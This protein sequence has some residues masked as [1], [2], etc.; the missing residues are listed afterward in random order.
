[1]AAPRDGGKPRK[2][3]APTTGICRSP[4]SSWPR[5][6][7]RAGDDRAARR[8]Q[9]AK[10]R[11]RNHATKWDRWYTKLWNIVQDVV[12]GYG[13]EPRRAL[14]WLGGL[15]VLGLLLFRY[16][17]KPLFDSQRAAP[18]VRAEQLGGLHPQPA[19]AGER[20]G[21]A[22][23]MAVRNGLGEVAAASLVVFG[24][25]LTATVFAAVAR[26]LQRN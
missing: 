15:F 2:P 13:Y 22:A 18:A 20:A 21:R 26:V 3:G 16:V 23:G 19:A 9:L 4:T 11:Q 6:T 7:V 25:L 24:W 14:V 12:I 17:A 1:M 8:I 5:R 10:Y